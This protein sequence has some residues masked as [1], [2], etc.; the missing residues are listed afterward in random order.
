MKTIKILK[1]KIMSIETLDMF[2]DLEK[3][4]LVNTDFELFVLLFYGF[5]FVGFLAI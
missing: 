1:T 5:H 3:S 4:A 2:P